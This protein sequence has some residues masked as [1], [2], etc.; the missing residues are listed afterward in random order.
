MS[1][2]VV[3]KRP[4]IL[5]SSHPKFD[6]PINRLRWAIVGVYIRSP[7]QGSS[8]SRPFLAMGQISARFWF[9]PDTRLLSTTHEGAMMQPAQARRRRTTRRWSTPCL[10]RHH[11]SQPASRRGSVKGVPSTK[12]FLVH[13]IMIYTL[14]MHIWLARPKSALRL[15]VEN[16]IFV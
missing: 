12:Y 9:L 16:R 6:Q 14:P 3:Q 10:G 5:A 8:V 15:G 1:A 11:F 4:E 7:A 13:F 2:R